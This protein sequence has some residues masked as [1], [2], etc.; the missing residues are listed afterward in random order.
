[1]E[2]LDKQSAD[3]PFLGIFTYTL[4][5]AELI[6]PEDSIYLAYKGHF[7]KEKTFGG[8]QGSRYNPT[9]YGH[10]QFAAMITRLDAM[11]GQIMA[12][13]KEK[14]L[15]ENTVVIFTSDNGPHEEGGADPDFFNRDGL[16]QGKY[17]APMTEDEIVAWLG[18]NEWAGVCGSESMH[19]AGWSHSEEAALPIRCVRPSRDSTFRTPVQ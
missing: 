1:M 16:L 17:R 11:V 8:N 10:A 3:K 4:P 18:S 7:C 2:W 19:L 14:G 5:H 6:Q 9:D 12:K 13:L 15:D